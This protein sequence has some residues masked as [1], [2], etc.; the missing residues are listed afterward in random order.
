MPIIKFGDEVENKET[1]RIIR[2]KQMKKTFV[3]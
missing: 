1:I 2:E 3:K